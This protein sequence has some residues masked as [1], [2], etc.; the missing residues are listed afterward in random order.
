[1]LLWFVSGVLR[2]VAALAILLGLANPRS[3]LALQRG[4][5]RWQSRLVAHHA[6]F[7]AE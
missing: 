6:S 7:V 1:M 2:V 3:I 5:L 4:V